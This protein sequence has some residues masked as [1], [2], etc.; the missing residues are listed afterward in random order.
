MR[1]AISSCLCGLNVRYDGSSKYDRELLE[2][3][4]NHEL[5]TIC[6]ELEAGFSVP[7]ESLE[8]R[9]GRVFT[10]SGKDVSDQL[11]SGC[12]R[13]LE[14][15]RDCDFLILKQKSPSC[16]KGTIYDG[17]FSG[18]LIEGN[19]AFAGLCL[20]HGLKVFSEEEIDAIRK[21]L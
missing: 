19:G 12:L 1:I 4:R 15:V 8:I 3:I 13:C 16:G 18:K 7:R 20:E 6:P 11:E 5:V 9:D 21:E 2:L 10:S 17:S 14:K